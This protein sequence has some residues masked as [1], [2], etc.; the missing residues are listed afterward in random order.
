MSESLLVILPNRPGVTVEIAF[1]ICARAVLVIVAILSAGVLR[2]AKDSS[3]R[4]SLVGGSLTLTA[5]VGSVYRS[6]K[7]H[8]AGARRQKAP[9]HGA[10]LLDGG[11][12]RRFLDDVQWPSEA[13][14]RFL[15]RRERRLAVMASPDEGGGYGD[16]RELFLG[17]GAPRELGP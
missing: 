13:G 8:C 16:P 12:V 5:R 9:H 14:T 17:D 11:V 3:A 1:G 7:L 4:R 6:F 10:G 2:K 15:G